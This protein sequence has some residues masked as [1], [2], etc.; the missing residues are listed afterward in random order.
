MDLEAPLDECSYRSRDRDAGGTCS[1]SPCGAGT[2]QG[3]DGRQRGRERG[4]EGDQRRTHWNEGWKA[5]K[6]K[7]KHWNEG[8]KAIIDGTTHWNEGWKVTKDGTTHWNE[9]WKKTKYEKT[10]WNEG[11]KASK[12]GTSHWNESNTTQTRR[13]NKVRNSRNPTLNIILAVRETDNFRVESIS[14]ITKDRLGADK[15]IGSSKKINDAQA[16]RTIIRK[17]ENPKIQK[18]GPLFPIR[19]YTKTIGSEPRGTKRGYESSESGPKIRIEPQTEVV[20]EGGS[21]ETGR[22]KSEEERNQ[23]SKKKKV[24]ALRTKAKE[25]KKNRSS[26]ERSE[27]SNLNVNRNKDIGSTSKTT[28]ERSRRATRT[29]G[30]RKSRSS[31]KGGEPSNLR[32]HKIKVNARANTIRDAEVV[33]PNTSR[34]GMKQPTITTA[35]IHEITLN[36]YIS[37]NSKGAYYESSM[38]VT[39]QVKGEYALMCMCDWKLIG[40]CMIV[41]N[42]KHCVW[43][44]Y[45]RKF[46]MSNVNNVGMMYV[47][48]NIKIIIT[49]IGKHHTSELRSI[50]ML[51]LACEFM[52]NQKICNSIT[53][54]VNNVVKLNQTISTNLYSKAKI[55]LSPQIKLWGDLA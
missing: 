2:A 11:W 26:T 30:A 37:L 34:V 3:Q 33:K 24:A 20:R 46:I 44:Y 52:C 50:T 15:R 38:Y 21:K 23:E 10:D 29:R 17:A 43:Y 39:E 41:V 8:W 1:H 48:T 32:V 16:N 25:R 9:G 22:W 4:L 5:T 18:L 31:T 51:K 7:T 19:K 6:D 42:L 53:K 40:R 27:P 47:V 54:S 55:Q 12:D 45:P 13:R 36:S 49:T 28:G 14:L 35:G